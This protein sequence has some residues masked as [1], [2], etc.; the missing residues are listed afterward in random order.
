MTPDTSRLNPIQLAVIANNKFLRMGFRTALEP[1]KDIKVV[2]DFDPTDHSVSQIQML[3]PE[4]ALIVMTRLSLD[5]INTCRSLKLGSPETKVLMLGTDSHEEDV[6]MSM[7]A[8]ASGYVSMNAGRPELIRAIHMV[9]RGDTY[10]EEAA[11]ENVVDRLQ[12]MNNETESEYSDALTKRE[13]DILYLVAE[14]FGNQAIGKHL[15]LATTT[16]R[17]NITNIRSKLGMR[18][19]SHLA[20]YAVRRAILHGYSAM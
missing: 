16:V 2:G 11:I 6:L 4:V 8:G 17:N 10:F 13:T 7:M 19:R 14:G 5:R 9:G 18:S 15:H 3:K 12:R 20:A 1:Q